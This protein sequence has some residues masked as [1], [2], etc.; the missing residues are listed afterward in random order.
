MKKGNNFMGNLM[1][2][3]EFA[4]QLKTPVSTVRTWKRRGDIPSECFLKIGGTI[5]VQIKKFNKWVENQ[6]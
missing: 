6:A 5:F 1:I 3:E 2:L 4:K